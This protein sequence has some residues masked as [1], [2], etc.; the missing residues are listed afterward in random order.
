[1]VNV[2]KKK[3]AKQASPQSIRLGEKLGTAAVKAAEKNGEELS[4]LVR[5]A[6][7]KEIGKPDL[8][9]TV[10]MGRPRKTLDG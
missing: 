1:M 4:T 8:A 5:R 3:P 2:A 7:A 6:V 9:D 10:R